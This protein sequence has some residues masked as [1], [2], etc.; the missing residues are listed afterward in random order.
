MRR[1]PDLRIHFFNELTISSPYYDYAPSAKNSTQLTLLLSYLIIN[2]GAK[3]PKDVLMAMLWPHKK[4]VLPIGALRNLIYRARKELCPLYP[5]QNIDY[6]KFTQDAYYWNE[7]L[8]CKTDINDFENYCQLAGQESDSERQY[9]Y[10]YRIN[11]LYK[12]GFL[13][14]LLAIEWVQARNA[15][16]RNIHINCTLN[17]C[18]QLYL[19]YRRDELTSLCDQCIILYPEE[20]RFYRYKLLAYLGTND[21]KSALAFYHSSLNFF[22]SKYGT[23]ISHSIQD[24]YEKIL[25]RI[26]TLEIGIDELEK[27]LNSDDSCSQTY[28]CNFDIFKTI[29][30]L[31]T[32]SVQ[33][34]TQKHYLLLVTVV[35]GHEKPDSVE[36]KELMADLHQIL[37]SVLARND[38]FTRTSMTQYSVILTITEENNIEK[39]IAHIQKCL[40]K[41]ET[42]PDVYLEITVREIG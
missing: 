19:K 4:D 33:Y 9:W 30:Q 22:S 1:K 28:Y 29:Y 24:V 3:V 26:P 15:Y 21:L 27:N 6:I 12:G 14:T 13:S 5:D 23:D 37:C 32:H 7:E 10:Y 16:F 2:Q 35:L 39:V 25:E 17:M 38:V 42:A 11:C 8:Y 18:E 34:N 36:V 41:P 40:K 20:N 31:N